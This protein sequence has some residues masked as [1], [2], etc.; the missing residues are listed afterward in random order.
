MVDIA[1]FLAQKNKA[2]TENSISTF[3]IIAKKKKLKFITQER[4]INLLNSILIKFNHKLN[5]KIFNLFYKQ[6]HLQR[7][8]K[9]LNINKMRMIMICHLMVELVL[10][11]RMYKLEINQFKKDKMVE[12]LIK[13]WRKEQK[14]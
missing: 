11:R 10:L 12:K 4:V 9:M 13:L 6:Q 1:L 7:L 8:L 14:L 3:T 5:R 2:N